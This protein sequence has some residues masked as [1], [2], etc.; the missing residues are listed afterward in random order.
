MLSQIFRGPRDLTLEHACLLGEFLGL[1]ELESRYFVAL[2][3]LARAGTRKYKDM[4]LTQLDELNL[5]FEKLDNRLPKDVE[6]NEDQRGIFYSEWYFTAIQL[7]TSMPQYQSL[8]RLSERLLVP[9]SRVARALEFLVSCG[10]CVETEGKYLV[11]PRRT[12]LKDDSPFI[13]Q[14]HRNW[15]LK[16][17]EQLPR[18]KH[19]ELSFS[20]PLSIAVKDKPIIREKIVRL[21]EEV[22]K[23]VE[24]SKEDTL[25]C[26]TID[27]FEL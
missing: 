18:T 17:M 10:L 4:I 24:V 26:L 21:I 23:T 1:G 8:E 12:H 7:L 9:K 19:D 3:Q 27:W 15:R 11:G 2:V 20:G 25:C 14:H 16:A 22:S 13:S 6:L 5:K